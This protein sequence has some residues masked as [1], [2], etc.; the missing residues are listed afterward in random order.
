VITGTPW[1]MRRMLAFLDPW[2]YRHD[3][4]YQITESLISVGSGGAHGMGLGDGRQKLFFLPEAHTDFILANIGEELGFIGICAV[5]IL[6]GILCWRGFRAAYRA[7]EPFGAFLAFGIT[8]TFGLQALVNMGVVMGS[9]PTKGLTLP[10]VS[11][12][13][14]APARTMFM[15]GGVLYVSTR[16]PAPTG[17]PPRRTPAARAQNQK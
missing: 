6:F 14:S 2:P 9:L 16:A 13:G 8:A 1:R 15:A 10:F 5:I 17:R 12:G 7:R 3:V 4:G 11:Y